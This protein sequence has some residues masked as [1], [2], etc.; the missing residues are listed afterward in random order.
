MGGL[1]GE[2]TH[3]ELL[4][5]QFEKGGTICSLFI[6]FKLKDTQTRVSSDAGS[7]VGATVGAS[8]PEITLF[9]I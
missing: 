7:T 6:K 8:S 9:A 3:Q 2:M 1:P 4:C 5:S